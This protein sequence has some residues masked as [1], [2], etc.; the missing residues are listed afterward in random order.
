MIMRNISLSPKMQWLVSILVAGGMVSLF[1]DTAIVFGIIVFGQVHFLLAYFYTNVQQKIDRSYLCR[2][3]GCL[4]CVG[5]L[6]VGTY[7]Y[8]V[9]FPWLILL[10]GTIFAAHY[11]ADFLKLS[12]FRGAAPP[13][14][15]IGGLASI[16]MA[17]FLARLFPTLTVLTLAV[18]LAGVSGASYFLFKNRFLL[19][20]IH[21]F[22]F[23]FYGLHAGIAGWLTWNAIHAISIN[24]ILGMIIFTHYVH[25]YL[26]SLVR[27][28]EKLG[29]YL[30]TLL[31]GHLLVFAAFLLYVL[32]PHSGLSLFFFHPA[33]FYG[34]T[35]IHIFMTVR[36]ADYT[37]TP[38]RA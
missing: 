4:L 20:G 9:Y 11:T 5:F 14:I 19:R 32:A 36:V 12:G 3:L 37:F 29:F 38:I 24:Q 25:W 34:W 6:A 33:F 22:F 31:W 21:S 35:L 30:D 16:F 27:Y 1:S 23:V 7:L 18:F 15:G 17:A 2:F 26:Y 13:L 28:Q 8:P 10:T